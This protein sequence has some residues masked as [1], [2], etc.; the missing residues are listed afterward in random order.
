MCEKADKT[1]R[2][3]KKY[4]EDKLPKSLKDWEKEKQKEDGAA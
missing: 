3:I 1:Y 4:N 2:M